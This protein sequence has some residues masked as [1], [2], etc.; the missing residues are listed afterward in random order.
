M[1][2]TAVKQRRQIIIYWTE[3][4]QSPTYARRLI[5]V[6]AKHLK[7]IAK[8][9]TAF[10]ETEIEGVRESAMG[11]F[12]VYYKIASDQIIVMAFWDNRQ[13]PGV[14]FKAVFY[15]MVKCASGLI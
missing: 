4:N 1:D 7:I 11:H 9:P 8:H 5:E 6:T 2:W 15:G 14:L 10:K 13:D 3:K 12:S